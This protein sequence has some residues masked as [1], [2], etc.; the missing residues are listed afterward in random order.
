MV[1]AI[2]NVEQLSLNQTMVALR[3]VIGRSRS[4]HLRS[5]ELS[6]AT[7]TV[8]NIGDRGA[9]A[10]FAVIYPPQVAIIGLG[11]PQQK[12]RVIDGDVKACFTI[13][14][15]LSADHRVSDGV[16]GAKFLNALDNQLQYPEKL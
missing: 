15:T 6:D 3:D 10:V 2:H 1:P 9:D 8:S 4:G 7:I 14:V 5:S 12:A 11:K 13:T 16:T